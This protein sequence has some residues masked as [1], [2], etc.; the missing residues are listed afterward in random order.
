MVKVCIV[1][2]PG[3]NCDLET[4]FALES[5]GAKADI[6]HINKFISG[7]KKLKEYEALIIPG[8]FSYGDHIRSGAIMGK[9][10]AEK[11]GKELEK[12]IFQQ[13]PVLGICNGFQVLVEAGFLPSFK[14]GNRVQAALVKNE[15]NRFECR[16]VYLK[17]TSSKCIFTK[18]LKFIRLPVAHAE[19]KFI[20]SEN[21][22][23]KLKENQQIVLRYALPDQNF[24]EYRYPFNPNGSMYDIAGICDKHGLVFGLMPHPERAFLKIMYPDWSRGENPQ[25]YGDG[26]YI[27][28]NMIEYIKGGI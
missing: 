3:T 5:L 28:K 7:R 14:R 18:G 1:R 23:E 13:K 22:L 6:I 2:A 4:K 27:F 21:K 12:F 17:V 24:A 20:I 9:I 19:G 10:L 16:W 25:D 15:S 26:Y 11:F 8:G